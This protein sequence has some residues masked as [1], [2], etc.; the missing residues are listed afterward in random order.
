MKTDSELERDVREELL[1]DA[2]VDD[3]ADIAV[4]AE[5]GEI[6]LRGT[7]ATFFQ[8][9]AAENAVKRVVGVIDVDNRIDVR[10]MTEHQRED[11]EIR[12]A[13][14][15][16]LMSDGQLPA[17]RLDV[18]VT[19]GWV[20]LSGDVDWLYQADAAYEDVVGLIG[21][22]G[23]TSELAIRNDASARADLADS[24]QSALVRNAQTDASNI[25]ISSRDGRVVLEGPV[26]SLAERDAAVMAAWSA[27][28]VV[29]VDDRL[30]VVR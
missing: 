8:K 20:R 16:R 12:A 14:L 26:S 10:L 27:P 24:I 15:Q 22:V 5:F 9:R 2:R 18:K 30:E 23:V 21:V 17:D 4:S 11:A 25:A 29:S 1:Y 7:V 19:D 28:G 6:T 13:A 3:P